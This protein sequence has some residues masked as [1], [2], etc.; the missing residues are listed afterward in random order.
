MV[1]RRPKKRR[2]TGLGGPAGTA[3]T[4]GRAVEGGLSRLLDTPAPKS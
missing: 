2:L 4:G 1:N 3:T